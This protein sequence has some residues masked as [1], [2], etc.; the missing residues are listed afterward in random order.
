MLK[1]SLVLSQNVDDLS[2]GYRGGHLS[3]GFGVHSG[4]RMRERS[5]KA[6]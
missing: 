5:V 1:L 4:E 3:F 2:S 6:V